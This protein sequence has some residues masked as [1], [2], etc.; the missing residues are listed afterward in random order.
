MHRRFRSI[1]IP[2]SDGGFDTTSIHGRCAPAIYR[3]PINQRSSLHSTRRCEAS[4]PRWVWKSA[5]SPA[6]VHLTL[7]S[8]ATCSI[9]PSK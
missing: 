9:C 2:F 6:P 5:I 3:L 4:G 1:L 8:M 7:T